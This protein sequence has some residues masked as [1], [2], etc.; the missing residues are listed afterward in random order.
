MTTQPYYTHA[1][2]YAA[3]GVYDQLKNKEKTIGL[4]PHE[5]HEMSLMEER[6]AVSVSAGDWVTTKHGEYEISVHKDLLKIVSDC[7]SV[8]FSNPI[9]VVPDK[10][11]LT[12]TKEGDSKFNFTH[13]YDSEMPFKTT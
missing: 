7:K 4:S 12:E 1:E 8:G 2:R 13:A 11:D 9:L 3:Q 5:E 6:F 10:N